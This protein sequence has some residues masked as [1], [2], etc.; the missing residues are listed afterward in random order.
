MPGIFI[1]EGLLTVIVGI[2]SKWWVADWP[3]SARFLTEEE[4]QVLVARLAQDTGSARMDHLDKTA[5]RRIAKDWKIYVG[6]VA[7]FGVVNTGYAGSVS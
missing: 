1:I 3:E 5:A 2:I 7:Y 4:R 6:T